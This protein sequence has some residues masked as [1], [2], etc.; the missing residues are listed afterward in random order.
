MVPFVLVGTLTLGV[1]NNLGNT[2]KWTGPDGFSAT[3]T[4]ASPGATLTGF[5]PKNVGTYQVEVIV[6]AGNCVASVET[7]DVAAKAVTAF[8]ISPAG[9]VVVC[10]GDPAKVLSVVDPGGV[11]LPMAAKQRRHSLCYRPSTYSVPSV[12][13]V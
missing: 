12:G 2:Y 6:S 9:A 10:Q 11:H 7:I 13:Y 8:Q 1:T 5:Q 4:S 3:G